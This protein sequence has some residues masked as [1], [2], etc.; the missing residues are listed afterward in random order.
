[1][2]LRALT[3]I[4]ARGGASQH[5]TIQG[6]LGSMYRQ[7]EMT[8]EAVEAYK[9]CVGL[10]PLA[11]GAAV[12]LAELGAFGMCMW[13]NF[14][15]FFASSYTPSTL[16]DTH[17][18]DPTT[19]TGVGKEEL[20]ALMTGSAGAEAVFGGLPAHVQEPTLAWL[21][22]FVAAHCA[23]HGAK[24]RY[25]EAAQRCVPWC[26]RIDRATYR[27]IDTFNKSTTHTN[28][29]TDLGTWSGS[30]SRARAT[31][32]SAARACRSS[33]TNWWRRRPRSRR[34]VGGGGCGWATTESINQPTN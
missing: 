21:E 19:H 34:C 27:P 9:A 16:I 32:C 4:P 1:M 8:A 10:H 29:T 2:A 14:D 17:T 13:I 33:R 30:S 26:S 25:D 7:M 15:L 31:A 23:M 24:P 12:A 20:W 6:G 28:G 11:L 5:A 18:N 3:S 22:S